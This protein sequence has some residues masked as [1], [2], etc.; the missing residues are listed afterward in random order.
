MTQSPLIIVNGNIQP[1]ESSIQNGHLSVLDRGLAY[2]DG[3]FETILVD[4]AHIALWQYHIERLRLGLQR[5]YI[6]LTDD[7][8]SQQLSK[9]LSAIANTDSDTVGVLKIMVTRGEGVRGYM[10]SEGVEPTIVSVFTPL[11]TRFLIDNSARQSQGVRVHYCRE[12]LPIYPT[13][14][15][16]KSLNQLSYVLASRERQELDVDEGLLFSTS[17]KLIEATAR[18][19]FIVKDRQ[20]YTPTLNECGVAGVMRR[21]II[22]IIAPS[23]SIAVHEKTL[24]KQDLIEADEVFLTNGISGIWPVVI[25]DKLSWPVGGVTQCLQ[26]AVGDYLA[27]DASLSWSATAVIPVP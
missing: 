11:S 10:P 2:G 8:L 5:L 13:L 17:N 3:V 6:T 16:V 9:T 23:V 25:C 12:Q 22:D 4:R 26:Q 21:L 18:N 24:C 15:G 1:S 14:A 27:S 7:R 19:I 20:L